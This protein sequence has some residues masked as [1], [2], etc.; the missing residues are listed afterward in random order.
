MGRP[1]NDGAPRPLTSSSQPRAPARPP[2][3]RRSSPVTKARVPHVALVLLPAALLAAV[4]VRAVTAEMRASEDAARERARSVASRLARSVDALVEEY[5]GALPGSGSSLSHDE[6]EAA[7]THLDPRGVFEVAGSMDVPIDH[8][9]GPL[10]VGGRAAISMTPTRAA[11][12]DLARSEERD[13]VKDALATASRLDREPNG[14]AAAAALLAGT[15]EA[16]EAPDL[17]WPIRHAEAR[18]DLAI[19]DRERALV[20]LAAAWESGARGFRE[21]D[22]TPYPEAALEL[23]T[24]VVGASE[25]PR[26]L[27]AALET[28]AGRTFFAGEPPMPPVLTS[29]VGRSAEHLR[30]AM[31]LRATASRVAAAAATE[32]ATVLSLDGGVPRLSVWRRVTVEPGYPVLVGGEVPATVIAD[33]IL[34]E[35]RALGAEPGVASVRIVGTTSDGAIDI[36]GAR[37]DARNAVAERVP[38]AGPLSGWRAEAVVAP[39]AGIPPTAWLLGAAVV[40][41]TAALVAGLLALRR[42]AERSA[43]LAEDRQTFLDHVAHELRTPA[44]AVQALTEELASGH[45]AKDREA[46]YRGHLLRESRRL[47]ALVEDTLDL[48]RLDAGR[49]AFKMVPA[50]L[51]DVV[52][53]AV[54]ESD[55]AGRVTAT[56]PDAPVV[57]AVD[58]GTLRRAVRNLVENA[59]RHGGGDAPVRVTLEASNGAASVVVADQGRGIAP[60]HQPRLFERF[61]RVP[62]ATHE[63][64]GVGLGLALCRE[65]ARAHGGDVTVASEPGK[66]STFTL[67]IPLA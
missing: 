19:G 61:Y 21:F 38:L 48:T 30:P 46:E 44:A 67:R 1:Y 24:Q 11:G 18:Y 57:R 3:V 17:L 25:P 36:A 33:R 62:S 63:V 15:A 58:E 10:R 29:L 54:E 22:G 9:A 53:R 52:R 16:V 26:W 13:L 5:A 28:C 45:V 39:E 59:I 12:W 7:V 43:R 56:V 49:L 2:S 35:A 65:V 41:T 50:D 20:A 60:E 66:G 4:G 14:A 34:G 8:A 31:R 27:V 64:K 42:S 37:S 47:S 40:V 55:G 51:R 6:A 23:A 32:P